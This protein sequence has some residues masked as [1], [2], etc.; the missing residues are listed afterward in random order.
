MA[1]H[2]TLD[3]LGIVDEWSAA[4]PYRIMEGLPAIQHK[5]QSREAPQLGASLS[6][7]RLAA[8][9]GGMV[10]DA[11][12]ETD[13]LAKPLRSWRLR[14]NRDASRSEGDHLV[15]LNHVGAHTLREF[16]I[17]LGGVFRD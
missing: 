12:S 4:L 14:W 1:S 15:G 17:K 3:R 10:V 2:K 8:R 6:G 13:S 7:L 9:E 16:R 5:T 11:D